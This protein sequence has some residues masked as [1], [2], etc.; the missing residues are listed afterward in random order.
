MQEH[1]LADRRIALESRPEEE[2]GGVVILRLDAIFGP[3]RQPHRFRHV[4]R[5]V[6]EPLEWSKR[7]L[8]VTEIATVLLPSEQLDR[9][10]ILR[11]GRVPD[12]E[13]R[14]ASEQ[15]DE[16]ASASQSLPPHPHHPHVKTA[17][18]EPI[19]PGNDHTT[20]RQTS[21]LQDGIGR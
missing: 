9:A 15:R 11:G 17:N 6:P 21:L 20:R 18:C 13:G 7:R 1:S 8:P 12:R 10:W 14:R 16:Q 3:Q 4:E 19:F 2:I 5:E